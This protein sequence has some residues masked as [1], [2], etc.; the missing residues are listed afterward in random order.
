MA[1][2]N[3]TNKFV[4]LCALLAGWCILSVS[5]KEPASINELKTTVNDRAYA[6]YW[7]RLTAIKQLGKLNNKEAVVILAD[8]LN[9]GEAPIREAAV[10]AL[11]SLTDKESVDWLATVAL[12]A[13]KD[14]CAR[15]HAAWVLGLIKAPSTLN[16]LTRA[17][18]DPDDSVQVK[19]IESICN[20]PNGVEA[21]ELFI[22]KL[23]AN[24]TEVRAS[25]ALA[26][27][28]IRSQAA[29]PHL[30][31][32][33]NDPQ[34]QVKGAVLET[35][36][37]LSPEDAFPHLLAALKNPAPQIRIIALESLA[38]IPPDKATILKA[39]S[40]LFSD[41]VPAVRTA[42]IQVSRRAK[43]RQYIPALMERL[44]D[45][46]WQLRYDIISALQDITSIKG[47]Y[48][49]SAWLS[50]Y[51]ANKDK[52]ETL[53]A[54]PLLD[55]NPD[56]T[57]PTFFTIPV[58]GRNIMFIIDFS[59]SMKSESSS[60][61]EG[62]RKI[63]V[64]ISELENTLARLNAQAYFNI[65]IMST[66]AARLN[67]RKIRPQMLAATEANRKTTI[68]SIR[69]LWNQMED[70]KRGRG[71][72]YDAVLEAMAEPAVDTI[73]ILSDGR[74]TYG[75]YVVDDNIIANLR[76]QNRFRRITMH[77]ILVGEKGVNPDLMKQI[78]EMTGGVFVANK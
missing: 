71:D 17:L 49:A 33:V 54:S 53:A 29:L 20:L 3:H 73:F 57:I 60:S 34:W 58:M 44:Q 28:R 52:I 8:L 65:V 18:N 13:P 4:L 31:K 66:E 27:G 47:K 67:K 62:K 68:D 72:L 9:D 35:L 15:C 11:S 48:N 10:M 12:F 40:E 76:L 42:A 25:A 59:G 45:A 32:R 69:A 7:D 26:L 70:I 56:Q 24:S 19:A 37:E 41:K 74:P 55:N 64:A 63:D 43:D 30:L 50:W 21:A 46:Q 5:A 61:A 14:A 77:T 39:V 36:T 1:E 38:K 16:C 2:V 23:G 22:K 51:A 6:N 75:A 78:A